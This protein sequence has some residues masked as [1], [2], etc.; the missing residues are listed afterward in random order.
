LFEIECCIFRPCELRDRRLGPG[1]DVLPR[2]ENEDGRD[3]CGHDGTR[4]E[5]ST[6]HLLRRTPQFT[7]QI[8]LD[9]RIAP[10]TCGFRQS[11]QAA[12]VDSVP[13]KT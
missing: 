3:M 13:N 7:K 8:V 9:N 2:Q 1:I 6:R 10:D 5:H 4:P 12:I 11:R